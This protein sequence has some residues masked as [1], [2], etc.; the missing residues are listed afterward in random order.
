MYRWFLSWR[1]LVTRRTNLIGI[2]GITV[3]VAALIL[4]LSIMTGFLVETRALLRAGLSDLVVA[5]QAYRSDAAL[6]DEPWELLAELRADPRVEAATPRLTW[7]A[8]VAAGGSSAAATGATYQNAE[9]Q[10]LNGVQVI[11]VDVLGHRREVLLGGVLIARALGFPLEFPELQDEFDTTELR[12]ELERES[13]PLF[14]SGFPVADP[15]RPFDAPKGLRRPGGKR[16]TIIV[17]EALARVLGLRPGS[18]LELAT[19]AE[20][21]TTGE[22]VQSNREFVV[23][24]TFRSGDNQL[25]VGRVYLDRRELWDFLGRGRTYS[26][27]LVKLRD[28]DRDS[29]ALQADLVTGL[30][31]R[32]LIAPTRTWAAT[33]DD[34]VRTWEDFRRT[35]LGAVENER[36]LLGIMLSLVLLVAGFT[37]FAIL[38]MMV[39]EKR[40]DIGILAAIGAPP[41]G[42]LSTFLTIGF[43]N[44]LLGT[45]LGALLGILGALRINQIEIW[46]SRQFGIVIFNRDVYAFDT[47]P[48]VVE[49]L[50]VAAI[51]LGAF[52]ITLLFA[53]I[54]AWQAARLN[55]VD[56]LRY[57]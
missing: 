21:P 47:I 50:S 2:V 54:P 3:A 22:F 31:A 5:P 4:I 41:R 27:V 18:E 24:G 15:L 29:A 36:V 43:W 53:A 28:Y 19:F 56:A 11:G 38:T 48:A 8:L 44:A 16:A 35:M 33:A 23:G 51:V 26:E 57:E 40:R 55:P 52:S 32:G 13:N 20:D 1:Y 30:T 6:P 34:Q 42:I 17:G 14:N 25:D 49:P 12:Q 45:G 46:L 9:F 39:G 10:G 7:F 37:I